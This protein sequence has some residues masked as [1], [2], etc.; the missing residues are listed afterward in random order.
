MLGVGRRER[1]RMERRW[2]ERLR[3]KKKKCARS[4]RRN[5][6]YRAQEED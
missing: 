4:V 3:M 5:C 6:C 1:R 2:G